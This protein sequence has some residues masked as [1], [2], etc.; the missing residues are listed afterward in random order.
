MHEMIPHYQAYHPSPVANAADEAQR[1]YES[2]NTRR[3]VRQF[4][5]RP[6][7]EGV[8]E[9][10]ILAAGT[11][12]S[13]ANAQ[14]W[15]F[16]IIKSADLKEK[17]R[18]AAEKVEHEFYQKKANPEWLSDLAPL[19]T[20]AHKPHLSVAPAIIAVFTRQRP[21]SM[22]TCDMKRSYYPVESTGIAVGILLTALHQSGLSTLTHTPRPMNFL[23]ELLDLDQSYRPF[24][25]VVTG[26][27][28]SPCVVP[29]IER[30]TFNDIARQY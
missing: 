25:M 4:S 23:N 3:S 19:G 22:Q 20:T 27:A 7:Q 1:F 21:L 24:L 13:G 10:A 29:A 9:N 17:L 30:K 26:H 12:P 16:A 6:I 2:M 28:A 5:E 18:A 15:F 8:L 11:A 14:P